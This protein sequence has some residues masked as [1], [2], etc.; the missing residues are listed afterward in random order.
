MTKL[1]S[2]MEWIGTRP[3]RQ[4]PLDELTRQ[5][6]EHAISIEDVGDYLHFAPDRYQRNLVGHGDAYYALVMCWMPGQSSPVHDHRGASCGV[7][8]LQ[9]TATEVRYDRIDGKLIPRDEATLGVGEVCG[10][11]DA[12]IHKITNRGD[13]GLVTLHVYSPFLNNVH[14]YDEATGDVSLFSDPYVEANLAKR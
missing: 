8:V 14:V 11:Y 12:D 9:G 1:A 2:F 4:I 13:E 5:L 7:R 10:S 6:K 3:E